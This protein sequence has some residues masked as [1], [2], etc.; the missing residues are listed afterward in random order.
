MTSVSIDRDR[1]PAAP[2]QVRIIGP[3]P[4]GV[5]NGQLDVEH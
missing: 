1:L 5:A 4:P 3:D 2:Y